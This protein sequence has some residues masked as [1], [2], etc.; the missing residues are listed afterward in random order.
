MRD[1][2]LGRSR[3]T[4]RDQIIELGLIAQASVNN[5]RSQAGI[6]RVEL[7]GALQKRSEA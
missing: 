7:R 1:F 2:Q 6:A 4:A 5:F 3:D